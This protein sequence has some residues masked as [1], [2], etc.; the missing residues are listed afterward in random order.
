M[1]KWIFDRTV[2]KVKREK[3]GITQ[4]RLAYICTGLGG[5]GS[6]KIIGV[7]Q[8]WG[9]ETGIVRPNIL[10]LKKLSVALDTPMEDFFIKVSE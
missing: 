7:R 5:S 9:W 10:N 2:I 1:S 8:I 6:K 3:L 4:E